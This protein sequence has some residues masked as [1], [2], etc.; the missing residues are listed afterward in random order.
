MITLDP[1]Q[2][3]TVFAEGATIEGHETRGK[4]EHYKS[5]GN[6]I[7][8]IVTASNSQHQLLATKASDPVL[9]RFALNPPPKMR[10]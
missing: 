8:W 6:M 3:Q 1:R 2:A 10:R 4:K 5:G 9:A 7:G